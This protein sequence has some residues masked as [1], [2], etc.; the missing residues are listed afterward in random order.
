MLKVRRTSPREFALTR[1]PGT[2]ADVLTPCG[3]TVT[4]KG[5]NFFDLRNV[6]MAAS[7]LFERGWPAL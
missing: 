2:P 1:K 3:D 7:R 6:T 5:P 4:R